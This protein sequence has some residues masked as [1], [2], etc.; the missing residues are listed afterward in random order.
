MRRRHFVGAL[1]LVLCASGC[2]SSPKDLI[3]GKWKGPIT[4]QGTPGILE[5]TREGRVII[6]ANP[7]GDPDGAERADGMHQLSRT[8]G[9]YKVSADEKSLEI[10]LPGK[11]GH[12]ET[13]E[14]MFQVTAD[15]LT[16]SRDGTETVLTRV[17]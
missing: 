6:Q 14:G 12:D 7:S 17:K 2:G 5:F 10:T 3:V 16:L 11:D 13:R 15:R 9:R 1:I 8:E 4:E